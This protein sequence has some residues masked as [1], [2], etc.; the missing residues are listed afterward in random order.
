MW[1]DAPDVRWHKHDHDSYLASVPVD[2]LGELA[3]LALRHLRVEL[4]VHDRPLVMEPD[5]QY[6][7]NYG[8]L[9]EWKGEAAPN[10]EKLAKQLVKKTQDGY[11]REQ[12]YGYY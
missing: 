7:T 2:R 3:E 9:V 12:L 8:A 11:I 10:E 5:M 6:G 4:R 1:E